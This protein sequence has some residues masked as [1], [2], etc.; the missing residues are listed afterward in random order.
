MST[1]PLRPYWFHRAA[2]V[3]LLF[4][5]ASCR[6]VS[7]DLR[8]R[9]DDELRAA[10][11]SGG[12]GGEGA[13]DDAD[14][15]VR[16]RVEAVANRFPTHVPSQ[17]AAATMALAVG[18]VQ[19]ATFHAQRAQVLEPGRPEVVVLL[20]R[21]AVQDGN[22]TRAAKELDAGIRARPDDPLLR[23]TRAWVRQLAD[24]FEAALDELDEAERLGGPAWRL[25]FHRGVVLERSG[26][27]EEA[28][29]AYK[30]CLESKPDHLGAKRR[31]TGLSGR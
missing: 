5:G 3:A 7:P 20:A 15:L 2:A 18:A 26:R 8:S 6:V 17:V 12:V 28:I 22:L 29:A 21:I 14:G 4:L 1:S 16:A 25:A 27:T 30:V 23:E 19:S 9:P 11:A 24:D 31:L 13:F 10:L